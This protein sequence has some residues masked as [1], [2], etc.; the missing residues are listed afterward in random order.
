MK[1]WLVALG[2]MLFQLSVAL[3]LSKTPDLTA[4]YRRLCQWDSEWYSDIV[5]RGYARYVPIPPAGYAKDNGGFFPG[6]PLTAR[7]LHMFLGLDPQMALLIVAQ[8]AAV[9][10][11]AVLLF[12]LKRWHVRLPYQGLVVLA[13]LAHPCS[14]YLV[15]GYSESLFCASLLLFLYLSQRRSASS[16]VGMATSGFT[17]TATR[18]LGLPLSGLPILGWLVRRRP[19]FGEAVAIAFASSL[20]AGLFFLFCKLHFGDYGHYIT[21]Q[22]DGWGVV[23]DYLAVFRAG[24]YHW[25]GSSDQ[26]SMILT[27]MAFWLTAMIEVNI[28]AMSIG[29]RKN[30]LWKVRFP[31]YVGALLLWYLASSGVATVSFRSLIRYSL[32]WSILLIIA[33][34]HLFSFSSRL[35]KMLKASIFVVLA[36]ALGIALSRGMLELLNR[37]LHSEWVS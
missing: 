34:T 6:Y 17:M 35:P 25:D 16:S 15:A 4:D 26:D 11:W 28:F 20:G 37:Y 10:F 7:A 12:L 22:R 31:W 32:P 3:S 9:V 27:A 1:I 13:V 19:K 36:I 30:G 8:S 29:S 33:W 2:I 18:I 5:E 14:F 21:T 23:P 24:N